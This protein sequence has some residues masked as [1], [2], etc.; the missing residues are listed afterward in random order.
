M[1]IGDNALTLNVQ[2]RVEELR[3]YMWGRN[4]GL[5][6]E[7]VK[8]K[9]KDKSGNNTDG[10]SDDSA[11]AEATL[12]LLLTLNEDLEIPGLRDLTVEVLGRIQGYSK[13]GNRSD[14]AME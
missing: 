7:P 9:L 13:S 3:L 11:D 1:V 14:S 8:E 5:V 6:K 12:I 10:E 2:F 4:W